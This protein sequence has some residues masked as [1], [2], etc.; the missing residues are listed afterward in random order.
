MLLQRAGTGTIPPSGF[1]PPMWEVLVETWNAAPRPK[2]ATVTLGP[3]TLSIGHY[4]DE[5]QDASTDVLGH[6]FGWDNEHPKREVEVGK[7]TI[8]WRPITNGEFH[9]FYYNGGKD[10]V[11]FPASWIENNG[12]VQVSSPER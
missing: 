5:E 7:F 6:D 1:I 8:E 12:E 9:D 11:K 2:T 3:E 10:K 4:D